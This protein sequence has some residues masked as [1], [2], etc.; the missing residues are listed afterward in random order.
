MA[1][2]GIVGATGL[3]GLKFL[4]ILEQRNFPVDTL[5]LFAS[6]R[7]AGSTILF[8][9]KPYI[10]EPITPGCFE[11]IAIALFSAGGGPSRMVAPQATSEGAIVIDNSSAWRGD[12][13]VPLVVPEVNA[14][15]VDWCDRKGIIANPNC[16]TIQMV[17]ALYPI[18]AVNPIKKIIVSTYQS[19][20]GAGLAHVQEAWL[21]SSAWAE[22]VKNLPNFNSKQRNAPEINPGNFI[23]PH[24]AKEFPYQIAFNLIPQ[25]GAFTDNGYTEEEMKMQDE[26]RKIMHSPA[27]NVSATT[28]RVPA[29]F[30][31]SEAVTIE[32]SYPME[33]EE[34]RNLLKSAPGVI[35]QDDPANK[36]YPMPLYAG[37]KD[38]TFVGRV[39]KDLA[40]DNGL[41]MWVVSDNIRK[42][43]ALNAIQIAEVLLEKGIK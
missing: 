35:L 33:A 38:E 19:V 25:I 8:K 22:K 23:S 42:G 6:E 41:S 34:A 30:A 26:T 29:F 10:V 24:P 37:G 28:I 4:E 20:S 18:H 17:V 43:A 40:F 7:S 12:P 31:H 21:Q 14:D 2:I 32:L 36:E 1:N 39:R 16:S 3:V 27:I 11:N 15:D 13:D 5:K 9:D